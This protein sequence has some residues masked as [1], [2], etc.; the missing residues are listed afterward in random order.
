MN[1]NNSLSKKKKSIVFN[2]RNGVV[3]VPLNHSMFEIHCHNRNMESCRYIQMI[4]SFARIIVNLLPIEYLHRLT[5][6][7][8]AHDLGN[9]HDF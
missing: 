7:E 2:Y 9:N 4:Y 1:D 3:C 8:Y 6:K 5:L